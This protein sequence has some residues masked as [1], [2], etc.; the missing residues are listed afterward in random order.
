MLVQ[1]RYNFKK[2]RKKAK[3][4]RRFEEVQLKIKNVEERDRIKNWQPPIDGKEIMQTFNLNHVKK[5]E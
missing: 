2:Q 1:I 3:Y 4:L 5:L